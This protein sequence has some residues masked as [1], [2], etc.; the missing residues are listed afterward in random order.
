MK[1]V[2]F[3]MN[4]WGVSGD[5]DDDGG[6]GA[7]IMVDVMFVGVIVMVSKVVLLISVIVAA[8]VMVAGS[9]RLVNGLVT[10][11]RVVFGTSTP[12][13]TTRWMATKMRMRMI[14]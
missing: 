13:P 1:I 11:R 8:G 4:E 14:K 9:L 12:A 10:V 6:G 2:A 3:C 7:E 5:D